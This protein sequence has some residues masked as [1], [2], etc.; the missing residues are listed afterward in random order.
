[1]GLD[2]HVR[3]CWFILANVAYAIEI[4]EAVHGY[5]VYQTLHIQS[6]PLKITGEL[7][8]HKDS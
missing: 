1:M 4:F 6:D 7:E 8:K 3:E 2:W 5:N